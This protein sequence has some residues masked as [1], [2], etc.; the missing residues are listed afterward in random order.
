MILHCIINEGTSTCVMFYSVW[1]KVISPYLV[2]STISLHAYDGKPSQPKG[3]YQNVPIQLDGK[4]VLIDVE[5]VYTPLDYTILLGHIY[6]YVMKEISSLV[7][8]TM[9]FPHEGN[10]ITIEKLTYCD[11]KD[12][13]NLDNVFPFVYGNH[14]ISSFTNVYLIIFKATTLLSAHYGHP[15]IMTPFGPFSFFTMKTS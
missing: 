5:V 13:L 8:H 11:T 1:K 4:K 7:F 9:S 14:L 2:S 10:I 15:P 12:H 3:L 6:M